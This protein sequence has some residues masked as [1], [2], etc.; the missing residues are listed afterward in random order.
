MPNIGFW[1]TAGAG[2]G[3]VPAFELIS[4]QILSSTATTITFSSI[5]QTY[6]HL[7]IRYV[8]SNNN[9]GF[10]WNI[11]FNS[12]TSGYAQQTIEAYA[13]GNTF[14]ADPRTSRTFIDI[15]SLSFNSL[16]NYPSGG[17]IDI[18]DYTNQNKYIVLKYMYGNL[19]ESS[20]KEV[21][22]GSGWAPNAG[23]NDII[24]SG[25]GSTL[26]VGSRFSL[27]GIKG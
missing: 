5:P 6:K 20:T 8:G 12:V 4:T 16:N 24:M 27:Y 22:F 15:G 9:P 13:D 25:Q 2:G 7:Q 10:R 19:N 18:L 17:I 14:I 26:S 3:G 21:T 1:A 23:V 11:K